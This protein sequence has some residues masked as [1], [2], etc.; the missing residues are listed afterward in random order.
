MLT[1]AASR[2]RSLVEGD[3]AIL[4]FATSSVDA[5][6]GV[7]A[8]HLVGDLDGLFAD[9]G[10]VLR[11]SGTFLVVSATPDVESNDATDIAYRM[12]SDLG[13]G[14]DR[15]EHLAARLEPHGFELVTDTDLGPEA[16]EFTPTERAAEI[17]AKTYSALWDLDDETWA[18]KVQPVIDG[19]RA[20]PEPDRPRPLVERH[21]LG[22]Y[23]AP[24]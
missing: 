7:W 12:G 16:S 5:V 15:P 14:W 20:L 4:P 6:L 19:L 3:A 22:I 24:G 11:P 2:H 21:K 13:R 10:R 23:R 1:V 17:E 8:V 18:T 9:V